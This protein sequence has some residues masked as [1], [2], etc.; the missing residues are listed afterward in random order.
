MQKFSIPDP[1]LL[2]MYPDPGRKI[3]NFGS[4]PFP[5]LQ[6]KKIKLFKFC[7]F[8]ETNGWK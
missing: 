5:E 3:R 4:G 6:M 8:D 7:S 1:K 2:I